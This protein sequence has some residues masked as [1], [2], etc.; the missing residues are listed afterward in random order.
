MRSRG[1]NWEVRHY[2]VKTRQKP[3]ILMLLVHQWLAALRLKSEVSLLLLEICVCSLEITSL[4]ILWNGVHSNCSYCCT[5]IETVEHFI[6]G[7]SIV[8]SN[9][10]I[11]RWWTS[12]IFELDYIVWSS[13]A[14]GKELGRAW[15]CQ[16][17][18]R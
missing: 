13:T 6:S 14:K 4:K 16:S 8:A 10:F 18:R 12:R 15:A 3:V 17:R 2:I 7:C 11:P 1:C 5:T 9:K